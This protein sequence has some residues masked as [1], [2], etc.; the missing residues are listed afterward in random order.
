LEK[1]AVFAMG[2]RQLADMNKD[3]LWLDGRMTELIK[4]KSDLSPTTASKP[5]SASALSF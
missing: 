2:H 1:Q 3:L 5:H 4:R